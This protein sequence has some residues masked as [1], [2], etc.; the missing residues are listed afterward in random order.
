MTKKLL[1]ITV[2]LCSAIFTYSQN[3]SLTHDGVVLEPN[4]EI[5]TYGEA[6]N[7]DMINH[8]DVTNNSSSD[9]NILVKKVENYLIDSTENTF[10]W[11]G[12]CY[13]NFVYLSPYSDN[14]PAGETKVDAFQGHYNPY[15][16][17]GSSSVSYV[18]FD[19]ANPNDSVMVTAIYTTLETG[20][21]DNLNTNYSLSQ[22]YPNPATGVVKF[23]YNLP[24]YQSATIKIYSMIGSLVGEAQ[25]NSSQGTLSYDTGLL[26]EGFYFY[27]LYNGSEKMESGKFVVKH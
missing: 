6:I 16:Q 4:A 9:M 7:E 5:I 8:L 18:F 3:I 27:S 23:D 24:N 25:M 11:A 1:I 21:G 14:I 19:E 10:C 13:A 15:G 20:I 2:I 26:E 17:P 12:L 22:P